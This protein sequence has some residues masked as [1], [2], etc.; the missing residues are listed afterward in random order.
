MKII[1][2]HGFNSAGYGNK[3]TKLKDAF[4]DENVIA[5]T[6]PYNPE[7]AMKLLE[8]LTE[9]LKEKDNL[10]LVGTSLG[11]FYGLYLGAKYKV[12]SV[13][14]NPSTDPYNSLKK[15]V[16]KQKNYKTDEEYEFSYKDLESLKKYYLSEREI[17]KA[18]PYI[19]VYL[20][21]EDELLDSRK[22][23]EFFEKFGIYVKIYPNGDH[24]FQHMDELIEDL[25]EK[26][27]L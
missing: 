25:R 9:T 22:T 15:Q 24:R 19:Y 2:I 11:G 23:K 10:I 7:K 17:E 3:I 26:L 8:F 13:L 21:E 18:K 12:P 14:I 27:N 20:D 4:G 5:L 6:L 16:G 1:Y